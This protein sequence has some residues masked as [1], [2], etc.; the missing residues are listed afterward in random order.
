MDMLPDPI[1]GGLLRFCHSTFLNFEQ[2]VG[3]LPDKIRRRQMPLLIWHAIS[4]LR[5]VL[6]FIHRDGCV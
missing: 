3:L 1:G 5:R 4:V 6:L 2:V